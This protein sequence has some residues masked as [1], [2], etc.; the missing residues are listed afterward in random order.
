MSKVYGLLDPI[1]V[2]RDDREAYQ[3]ALR[4]ATRPLDPSIDIKKISIRDLADALDGVARYNLGMAL[5][6]TE[7]IMCQDKNFNSQDVVALAEKWSEY[8]GVVAERKVPGREI[9]GHKKAC[10]I[11]KKTINQIDVMPWFSFMNQSPINTLRSRAIETLLEHSV[12]VFAIDQ[13]DGI[14]VATQAHRYALHGAD[15][16]LLSRAKLRLGYLQRQ[17]ERDTPHLRGKPCVLST[18]P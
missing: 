1:I 13:L 3:A 11:A 17:H 2:H 5:K 9:F 15:S 6:C 16:T 10:L 18:Q 4:I 7:S 8:L 14:H 12:Q